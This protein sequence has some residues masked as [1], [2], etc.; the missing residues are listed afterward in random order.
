MKRS[1]TLA[2]LLTGV[3]LVLG[4]VSLLTSGCASV[5]EL[6][7]PTYS[8]RDIRPHISIAIPLAASSIDFNFFLGVDNPNRISLPVSHLDFDLFANDTHLVSAISRERVTIPAHGYG[9]VPLRARVGYTEIRDVWKSVVDLITGNRAH[10]RL[11]GNAY[12]DTPFGE[13]RFP[14]SVVTTR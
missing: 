7:N 5:V 9:E 4:A 8:V 6:Q 13:R 10:Y 3:C 1:L 12:Y 11:S 14:V 2:L